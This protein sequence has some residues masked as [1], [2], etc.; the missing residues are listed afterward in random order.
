[1]KRCANRLRIWNRRSGKILKFTQTEDGIKNGI[2]NANNE[3]SGLLVVISAPSG[4]GKTSVL[5][6]VLKRHP[7]IMFSVSVTTRKQ[8]T[9]EQDGINYYFVSEEKFDYHINNDDFA[10][11]A[12]V[13]GKRYGTL[14]S[15][16][17]E[18]L[19]NYWT[20]LLDT[21]TGGAF[22][23][24]KRYPDAVLIF[25]IPPSPE[26]LKERLKYRNTE[27][28]DRIKKR[29]EAAPLEIAQMGDYDYIVLNDD[30]SVAASK[31]SAV[32]EAERLRSE[33]LLP[34]LSTWKEYLDG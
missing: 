21:D 29:L 1:M 27:S 28:S 23:I 15:T 3:K 33:R 5:S 10:E 13:H 22:N 12:V 20:I 17:C 19:D 16:I 24:K 14:M 18:G 4:T 9:G 2:V 31:V 32:I 8:R 26:V 25:L 7:D 30:L 11:W 34:T 6:E